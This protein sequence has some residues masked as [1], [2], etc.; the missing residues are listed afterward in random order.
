MQFYNLVEYPHLKKKKKKSE[1]LKEEC[2]NGKYAL[3]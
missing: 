1:M 3:I 2:K